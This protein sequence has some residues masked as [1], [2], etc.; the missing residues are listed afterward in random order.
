MRICFVIF[1]RRFWGTAEFPYVTFCF[2]GLFSLIGLYVD[3]STQLLYSVEEDVTLLDG[4]L[5]E[6]E[7]NEEFKKKGKNGMNASNDFSIIDCRRKKMEG[8]AF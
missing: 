8:E 2:C 3:H 1:K 4:R 7:Q 6:K 5:K